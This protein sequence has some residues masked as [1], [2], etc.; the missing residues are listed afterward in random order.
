MA[1]VSLA[2]G[3]SLTI[4]QNVTTAT[5]RG[6][7]MSD[8]I[9]KSSTPKKSTEGLGP[10]GSSPPAFE[11]VPAVDEVLENPDPISFELATRK[12]R[13]NALTA[14]RDELASLLGRSK[15]DVVALAEAASS[16]SSYP[17]LLERMTVELV[18]A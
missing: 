6:I 16:Q 3:M 7:K 15:V 12:P 18:L 11:R 8:L 5:S 1:A 10:P 9:G 14:G 4:R 2:S 13:A 17:D